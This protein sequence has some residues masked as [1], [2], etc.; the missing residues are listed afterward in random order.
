M[1]QLETSGDNYTMAEDYIQQFIDHM[2]DLKGKVFTRFKQEEKIPTIHH[3]TEEILRKLPY[4]ANNW[5]ALQGKDPWLGLSKDQIHDKLLTFDSPE[6]GIRASVVSLASR[7]ARKN[8]NPTL[9][10]NQI[11][12][13][14][15]GWAEASENYAAEFKKMGI[16]NDTQYNILDKKSLTP[17][18]NAMALVEMGADDYNSMS[19][20]ERDKIINEGIDMAYKYI[21]S[22]E[23]GHYGVFYG[24]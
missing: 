15:D 23:Y 22:P 10:I 13:E 9:T 6:L 19:S 2:Q 8:Q 11:F 17:L 16:S 14:K 3:Q 7:A 4:R 20:K 1:E 5:L 24:D 18:V 21:S 12:F